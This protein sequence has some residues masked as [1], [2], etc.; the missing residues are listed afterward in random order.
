[1]FINEAAYYEKR[2]AMTLCVCREITVR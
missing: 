2:A 1:M